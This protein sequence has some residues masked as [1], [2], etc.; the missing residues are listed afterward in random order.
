MPTVEGI[1]FIPLALFFF[2]SRPRLLFPLLIVS[3]VF[4]ASSVASFVKLGIQ[5][6][7]FV[8]IL[9]V[10]R[11]LILGASVTRL[12]SCSFFWPWIAFVAVSWISALTF[13]F[14]F[15]GL[16]VIDP[17]I[18]MEEFI[19]Q[20]PMP[21]RFQLA[22]IVQPAFLTLNVLVVFASAR[23][24][25]SIAKAHKAFKWSAY[26]IILIVFLQ[27][28]CFLLGLQFPE[29]LLNNNPGYSMSTYTTTQPRPAGTFTEPSV[30][31]AVL[32][33]LFAVFLWEF[34]KGKNNFMK[35]GVAALACL[36]IASTSSLL[37]VIIVSL[38]LIFAY[39]VVRLP[40]FI[41]LDRLKRLSVL[42]ISVVLFSTLLLGLS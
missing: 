6:Y 20:G 9:F 25:L 39:P 12:K 24:G 26:L 3:T 7:Y 31:G 4:E 27:V 30:A 34:I 17:R 11:F 22:N 1:V 40:W 5:P 19:L 38:L 13:P 42:L 8:A 21:L 18:G 35:A 29:K 41:R 37:T 14:I 16:P 23:G 2:F 15:Q 36:L 28:S 32:A 10:I 33:A